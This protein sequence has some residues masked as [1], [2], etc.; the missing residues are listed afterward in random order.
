MHVSS[1][2][3][4]FSRLTGCFASQS[5]DKATGPHCETVRETGSLRALSLKQT[6]LFGEEFVS[7]RLFR[8]V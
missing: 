4:S 3:R 6:P 5:R 8:G 2:D 1:L 7:E